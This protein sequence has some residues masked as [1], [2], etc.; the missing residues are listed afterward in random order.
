MNLQRCDV[1]LPNDDQTPMEFVVFVCADA[2]PALT[3]STKETIDH[4]VFVS[5][6][7][8][9][10]VLTP[11]NQAK[12]KRRKSALAA[13]WSDHWSDFNPVACV[14]TA[15]HDSVCELVAMAG[16][17][18]ALLR[19]LEVLRVLPASRA[20]GRFSALRDPVL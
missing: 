18:R 4:T 12:S 19:L 8:D 2:S 11:R 15:S 10:W 20:L 16:D 13:A 17:S 9:L 6:F 3:R 1:V 7:P 5:H 14:F